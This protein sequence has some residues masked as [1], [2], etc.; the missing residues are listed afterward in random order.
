VKESTKDLIFGDIFI[1]RWWETVALPSDVD[2]VDERP[3]RDQMKELAAQ[4]FT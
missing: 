4:V 1:F 3:F 2:P